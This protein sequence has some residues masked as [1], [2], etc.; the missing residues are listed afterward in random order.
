MESRYWKKFQNVILEK[1]GDSGGMIR[2]DI[3]FA[4]DKPNLMATAIS[5]RVDIYKLT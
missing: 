5:A 3:S 4:R 2:S 1:E